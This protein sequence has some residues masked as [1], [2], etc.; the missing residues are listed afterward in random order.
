MLTLRGPNRECRQGI[1]RRDVLRVGALGLGSLTLAEV[2]RLRE[3]NA[4]GAAGQPSQ[5][6]GKSVIMIWLR[7]GVA[8]RQLRH[9]ARCP[10]GSPGRV[11]ADPNERAG[12]RDLRA[13]AAAGAMMDSLAIIRGIK[14]NDLGDHTPHYILTG[15]PDRGKRPSLARS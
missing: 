13:H 12:H 5:G 14:S 9:E 15:F 3:C 8:H 1:S 4:A 2:L 10:G 7:G 11:S 6:R